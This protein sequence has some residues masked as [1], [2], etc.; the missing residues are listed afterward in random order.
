LT[1][2]PPPFPPSSFRLSTKMRPRHGGPGTGSKEGGT[3]K[4]WEEELERIASQSSQRSAEMMRFGRHPAAALSQGRVLT[5][6]G[7][8][9]SHGHSHGHRHVPMSLRSAPVAAMPA[10]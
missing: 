6:H 10:S 1:S 2:L 3:M 9:H 8:S 7:H 5:D 4:D